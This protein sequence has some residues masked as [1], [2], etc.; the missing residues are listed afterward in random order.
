MKK[1]VVIV[2]LTSL[3][4]SCSKDETKPVKHGNISFSFSQNGTNNGRLESAST[5]KTL[6]F[7]IKDSNGNFVYENKKI[8]LTPFGNSY[9]SENLQLNVGNLTLTQFI[10]LDSSDEAIYATPVVGSDF[11]Q[12]VTEPLPI[13]FTVTEN[14][15]TTV[16]PQVIAVENN[17]PT[18]FGY[19]NFGFEIVEAINLTLVVPINN[20]PNINN[21]V[22]KDSVSYFIF[23]PNVQSVEALLVNG[24]KSINTSL[25]INGG[26]ASVTVPVIPGSWEVS[27][28]VNLDIPDDYIPS[29]SNSNVAA[30]SYMYRLH[31][32][33]AVSKT[34]S[35]YTFSNPATGNEWKTFLSNKVYAKHPVTD[36]SF[37]LL[38]TFWP[39]DFIKLHSATTNYSQPIHQNNLIWECE[40]NTPVYIDD[41]ANSEWAYLFL[42]VG[43]GSQ[44]SSGATPQIMK[45]SLVYK[46][47]KLSNGGGVVIPNNSASS[48]V[49]VISKETRFFTFSA[50]DEYY[51]ANYV[52]EYRYIIG[53]R[54][55][56]GTSQLI[57]N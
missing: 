8:N 24:L 11:A 47:S 6:L 26:F 27:L 5:P 49:S 44:L 29:S 54:T 30:K 7:S 18:S 12:Y 51:N 19:I 46:G 9:V 21:G 36:S 39:T 25:T 43:I 37:V 16:I 28:K 56:S 23:Y 3:V 32:F 14:G 48:P 52:L 31:D 2:L 15:T 35:T 41:T 57:V 20:L 45:S 53:N 4:I 34:N 33:I 50:F 55:F 10:I 40:M 42:T 38:T 17:S 13:A 22:S 1:I